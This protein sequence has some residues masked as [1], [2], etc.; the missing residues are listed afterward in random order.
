MSNIKE[1]AQRLLAE[2][3]LDFRI[4]KLPLGAQFG[5]QEVSS[6]Y[7]GLYNDQTGEIINTVKEGYHISQNDE[8][9]EA[10]LRGSQRFGE[11]KINQAHSFH[12]GRRTHISMEIEGVGRVSKDVIKRYITVID[13]ND[14]T[15]GLLVG[16]GNFTMSCSNLFYSFE[17]NG[18][19]RARHTRSLGQKISQIEHMIE[20]QLTASMELMDLYNKFQST[21][22]SRDLA[23]KLVNHLLGVDRLS[24]KAQL[25][26]T[27]T[28]TL[29]AMDAL[30][31]NIENE[32][33]CKG[34]NLW[35][36]H[37]GVTRWTTHEK[38]APR[39]ENGRLESL[40]VGTNYN[41]NL[42]SLDFAKGLIY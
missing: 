10:V 12:G 36:L 23:H 5:G 40:T 6:P 25:E 17:E 21:T 8:I 13:S 41:T 28:R 26:A 24:D 33:N 38:S 27:S 39:R 35:G 15:S 37:S 3:G 18:R 1:Q 14:G 20:S 16:I 4:H 22:V 34:D 42:Q 2:H 30:Y 31:S 9:M 11:L 32:M 19:L 7:Y 29:N